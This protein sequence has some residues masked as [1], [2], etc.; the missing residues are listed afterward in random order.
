MHDRHFA[1][2]LST[3][4]ATLRTKASLSDKR[5]S[6]SEV[7]SSPSH[8]PFTILRASTAVQRIIASLCL[9]KGFAERM[10]QSVSVRANFLNERSVRCLTHQS[11]SNNT[12]IKASNAC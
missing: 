5:C 4:A 2:S 9:K 6:K 3:C 7:I 11:E 12:E 1:K 8:E 10:R